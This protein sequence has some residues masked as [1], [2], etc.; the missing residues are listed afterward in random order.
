M[1]LQMLDRASSWPGSGEQIGKESSLRQTSR[2][3]RSAKW[4]MLLRA[5]TRVSSQPSRTISLRRSFSASSTAF[6]ASSRPL[7]CKTQ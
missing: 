7:V 1:T 4:R 3:E 2:W 6:P 5:R